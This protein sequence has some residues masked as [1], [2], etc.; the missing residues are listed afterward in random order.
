MLEDLKIILGLNNEDYDQY[1]Q[2]LIDSCK[3]DLKSVGIA[4]SIVDNPTNLIQVAI[5]TYVKAEFDDV[6]KAGLQEA[7]NI[8]KDNLRRKAIYRDV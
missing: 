6:N 1:I 3:E 5:M 8:Q 2:V 4:S 7:Y